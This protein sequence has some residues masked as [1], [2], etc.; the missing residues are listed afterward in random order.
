MIR[1]NLFDSDGDRVQA[2]S[3][4]D[5]S[6]GYAPAT[7]E[8]PAA[9]KLVKFGERWFVRENGRFVEAEPFSPDCFDAGIVS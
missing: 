8:I 5:P 9:C 3:L 7:I 6:A 4:S 1:V 2:R